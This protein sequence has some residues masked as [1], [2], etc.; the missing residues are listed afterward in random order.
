MI[1]DIFVELQDMRHLDW[2]ERKLSPG[3]PGCFLKAYDEIEGI[4]LKDI[5]QVLSRPHIEKIW[6]MIWKRWQHYETLC[7]KK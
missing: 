1:K 6:E 5:D 3:T 7:N 4:R 2:A